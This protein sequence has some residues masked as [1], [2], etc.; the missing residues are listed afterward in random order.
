V[1]PCSADTILVVGDSLSAGYGLARDAGWVVLLE[2][3]LAEDKRTATVINASI[4]GETT[5]GGRLR[6]EAL[7]RQHQPD[8]V[9]VEL[10][11]NDGLRGIRISLMQDN[12]SA[13]VDLCRKHGARVVVIGMRI[14]PNYGRDYVNR[15]HAAYAQVAD[16]HGA[17]L[18]PF[19]LA[20]FA[21]NQSM[22]QEDGIHPTA[23]A[24][25]LILDN[26]YHYLKPML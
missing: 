25:Q 23:D 3:Q 9:I 19:M 17:V 22:F 24:Q 1:R 6:I 15:F 20:G 18:V 7:L 16:K 14:P 12:L 11:A 2:R 10:G 8:I 13:I 5:G 21:D 26:I 4:S